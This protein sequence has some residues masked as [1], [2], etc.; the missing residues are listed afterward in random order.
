MA[1][2]DK[3]FMETSHD[4]LVSII[5]ATYN[6][7]ATFEKAL[8]SILEQTYRNIEIVVIDDNT[9]KE[10]SL[11]V[12]G[13]IDKVNDP[14]IKYFK[15]PQNLGSAKSREKGVEV[16]LGE[17]ITFLDDDDYYYNCKIEEQ[18]GLMI[19]NNS[20]LSLTNMVLI[21]DSTGKK[22][23][24]INRKN[25]IKYQNKNLHTFHLLYHLTGTDTIMVRKTFLDKSV[26][27]G[28]FDYGDEFYFVSKILLLKPRFIHVDKVLVAATLHKG[29]GLSAGNK[30]LIGEDILFEYKKHFFHGLSSKEKRIITIRHYLTKSK[31]LL[32]SKKLNKALFYMLK[33]LF[34]GPL[35]V[36][37]IILMR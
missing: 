21:N 29:D 9:E 25:L 31:A 15:N 10:N 37:N 33:A 14:R 6:Q 3:H 16:S 7:K 24:T 32:K 34:N 8:L 18:L 28:L 5:L 12:K 19:S 2:V 30:R 27:F 35:L 4:K 26:N 11:Y 1:I 17:F 20:D 36:L 22:V 13:I 23:Y